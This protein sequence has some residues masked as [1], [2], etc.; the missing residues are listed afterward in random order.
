MSKVCESQHEV[1]PGVMVRCVRK[2][3]ADER[4]DGL[5]HGYVD[6]RIV[7]WPQHEVQEF[8][9]HG[10]AKFAVPINDKRCPVCNADGHLSGPRDSCKCW[11]HK[12]AH[13]H[14]G[15]CMWCGSRKGGC[16]KFEPDNFVE[17]VQP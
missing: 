17:A 14:G 6:G 13:A 12:S 1:K 16:Q 8:H 2:L 7:D 4:H 3:K 9:Y 15:R 10:V 5:H 11:H